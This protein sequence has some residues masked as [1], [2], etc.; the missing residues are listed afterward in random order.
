MGEV[1][2]FPSVGPVVVSRGPKRIPGARRLHEIDFDPA[3]LIAA[4]PSIA[5]ALEAGD[6][7]RIVGS[8]EL[9]DGLKS[10]ALSFMPGPDGSYGTVVDTAH[11][12]AGQVQ[13]EPDSALI[14]TATAAA[15]FQ[16]ASAVTLQYYL[17]RIDTRLGEIE[18]LIKRNRRDA[19]LAVVERAAAQVHR[20][21]IEVQR[22]PLSSAAR[23]RL[24]VEERAV[25]VVARQERQPLDDLVE[26]VHALLAE[27]EV[28]HESRAKSNRGRKVGDE[29]G[30]HLPRGLKSK[31]KRV[32]KAVGDAV[33]HW[34]IV[35]MAARVHAALVAIQIVD[36]E[37]WG[38]ADS[39]PA[40]ADLV[41]RADSLT[42]IATVL[43]ALPAARMQIEDLVLG[44]VTIRRPLDRVDAVA[45]AVRETAAE[46]DC[47]LRRGAEH[48][49]IQIVI[50]RRRTG[51]LR[52]VAG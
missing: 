19:A 16:L 35:C 9:L 26:Q 33:G 52:S 13:F 51:A 14:H 40:R 50:T 38:S 47:A 41:Q 37:V 4:L 21:A 3:L 2:D 15:A 23:R 6:A 44:D 31:C 10:G 12:I 32:A 22:G 30:R 43:Q 42:E 5:A 17:H 20:L 39:R 7:V 1:I 49:P 46:L 18:G 48:E 45:A 27:V 34:E 11:R 28:A 29:I 24:D 25:D 8:A 36:D